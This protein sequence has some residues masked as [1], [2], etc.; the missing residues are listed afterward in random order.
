MGAA[1]TGGRL[2]V[3]VM[4][5]PSGTED[6]CVC[7]CIRHCRGRW[8]I[9]VLVRCTVSQPRPHKGNWTFL[10]L[11]ELNIVC[12]TQNLMSY[13]F[14][15]VIFLLKR[16]LTYFYYNSFYKKFLKRKARRLP[17]FKM[18]FQECKSFVREQKEGRD[19]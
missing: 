7:A 3:A 11:R 10:T 8:R 1:H 17:R 5:W 4:C 12:S 15:C 16:E 13:I 18:L 9:F 2:W 6:N 19:V 14:T